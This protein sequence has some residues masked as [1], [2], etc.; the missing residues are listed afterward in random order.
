MQYLDYYLEVIWRFFDLEG[1]RL[2]TTIKFTC[3]TV[4]RS[5]KRDF[6][7]DTTAGSGLQLSSKQQVG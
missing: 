4:T 6:S 7:M 5:W 3:L 1:R 2:L